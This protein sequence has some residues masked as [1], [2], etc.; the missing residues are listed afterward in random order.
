MYKENKYRENCS[1]F[2]F[3][4]H[5]LVKLLPK[6]NCTLVNLS[7]DVCLQIAGV[8]SIGKLEETAIG[9]LVN[10]VGRVTRFVLFLRHLLSNAGK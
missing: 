3:Q 5:L 7:H 10:I 6:C 1:M 2:F 9:G 4:F 8:L